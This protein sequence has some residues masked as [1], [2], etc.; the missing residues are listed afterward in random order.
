M[1]KK[2]VS[3]L[4][5]VSMLTA[6][7]VS[8]CGKKEEAVKDE[9]KTEETQQQP[10]ES[11]SEAEAKDS[12]EEF[13]EITYSTVIQGGEGY[14][15]ENYIENMIEE[16]LNIEID[17]VKTDGSSVSTML[18]TGQMPNCIWLWDAP[19]KM[20]SEG[21]A[22]PIPLS[23]VKEYAPSAYKLFE[24][25]PTLLQAAQNPDN[26][27]EVM[28]LSGFSWSYVKYYLICD[29]YRY[30]WIENLGIDLGVEVEQLTDRIYV[31]KEGI[32]LSK[33]KE[34]MD[35]FVNQDPD[36]N[37]EKDTYGVTVE[38]LK[39][40][41]LLSANGLITGVCEQNGEAEMYY[42]M[43]EYKEYL[44]TMSELQ[45][46]GLA[47]SQI[48]EQNRQIAWD[49][50]NAGKSGY[51]IASTNCLAWGM[52]ERPPQTLMEADPDA[53]V[54]LTPGVRPDGGDASMKKNSSPNW[55]WF[56]V[57]ADVEED[58]LIRILQFVEWTAMQR[59]DPDR[60]ISMMLGE[61]DVDWK[62]DENGELVKINTIAPMEKG[63]YTFAL[64][65]QDPDY[66]GYMNE[67]GE[68]DDGMH[69]WGPDGSWTKEYTKYQYKE[70]VANATSY[71]SIKAEKEADIIAYADSYAAQAFLGQVDVDATWEEYLAELDRLGYNE[72]MSELDK[73]EPLEALIHGEK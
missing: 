59:E 66:V 6:L 31:A 22:K 26:P 20:Y 69:Y 45:A 55:G 38:N 64:L 48:I 17:V 42:A 44:K 12:L 29:Y 1:K 32:E 10:E 65:G 58:K 27:D 56:Y 43:D 71:G 37:G 2:I 25:Y 5:V 41:C 70:D 53:K 36:G 39:Q 35:A 61:K 16:N 30:D 15:G 28:G 18:A 73:V 13:F 49:K 19:D 11:S 24:E 63:T 62:W 21:L 54:L 8:G 47:D 67:I 72:M 46:D 34:I 51:W 68:F 14:E 52:A 7:T 3:L 40:D 57:N 9:V 60:K 23:L 50:V 33:F 4:L